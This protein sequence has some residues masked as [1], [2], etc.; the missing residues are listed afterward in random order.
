MIIRNYII[1]LF[2]LLSVSGFSQ[3]LSLVFPPSSY[4]LTN[5]EVLLNWNKDSVENST[6]TIKI[7]SDS[8]LQNQLV[9]SYIGSNTSYHVSQLLCQ[10]YY[11]K[12]ISVHPDLSL[13]STQLFRFSYFSPAC[14]DSL[15]LWLRA[16]KGVI[17]SP[18]NSSKVYKW[19]DTLNDISFTQSNSSNQPI[20]VLNGINAKP[21]LKFIEDSSI[22]I[23]CDS[24]S[25]KAKLVGDPAYY[26]YMYIKQGS[27][28][29]CSFNPAS[30][31]GGFYSKYYHYGPLVKGFSQGSSNSFSTIEYTK[32]T[33]KIGA[34]AKLFLNGVDNTQGYSDTNYVP[35][36]LPNKSYSIG[37]WANHNYDFEGEIF[38]FIIAKSVPSDTIRENMYLYNKNVLAPFQ[39]LGKD[40]SL[41]Y[42]FCIKVLYAKYLSN[43][44]WSTGSIN[45]SIIISTPGTYWYSGVDIFGR[46]QSDTIVV[47][48]NMP[49]S[50]LK[51]VSSFCLGD[52]SNVQSGF[53]EGYTYIWK[54]SQN[55]I[56]STDSVLHTSLQDTYSLKI[57]DTL[58]CFITDT[59]QVFVD[60]FSQV[61]TLGPNKSLCTGDKIGLEVG[62]N[63]ADSF[64]WNT[65][66]TDSLLQ[67]NTAG[68][69]SLIVKDTI[70][71]IAKDTINVAI[72]GITPYVAFSADTVCFHDSSIFIDQ[73]QSLDQSNLI[74]W[75]W[76]FGDGLSPIVSTTGVS[77]PHLYPDS[78]TYS[79]K[80]TVSTDSNC[81]NYAYRNVYVRPLP[82]PN[83]YPLTGCQNLEITFDNLTQHTDS[84]TSFYWDFGNGDTALQA[85]TPQA[86][87][88]AGNLPPITYTYNQ[89][90]NYNTLLRVTDIYG[91]ADSITQ[92][93]NIKP[94]PLADFINS[95]VCEGTA[96]SFADNSVTLTY[97]PIQTWLWIFSTSTSTS[98]STSHLFP[99][100]GFYPTKLRIIAVNGCWDTITKLVQVHEFPVPAFT[101]DTI[102]VDVNS[103]FYDNSS[104]AN[105]SI[106]GWHWTEKANS[107]S[108][109]IQSPFQKSSQIVFADTLVHNIN[110]KV[111]SSAGCE[112]TISKEVKSH[113]RPIAAFTTDKEYGLPPLEVQF[114]NKSTNQQINKPTDNL[115]YLWDFRDNNQSITQSP[116]HTYIDSAI[117]H[118]LLTTTNE[119]G[120]WDTVSQPIYAIYAAID[121]AMTDVVAQINNG[122]I[123]YSCIISN[124]GKQNLK[125]LLIKAKYN[126]GM[127]IAETWKGNLLS[128]QSMNYT[129][130]SSSKFP[131]KEQLKFFCIA[132]DLPQNAPQA[133]EN[134][135]N[136]S[137]CKDINNQFWIGTPYPNPAQDIVLLDVILPYAQ[138]LEF[139]ITDING[140]IL[141]TYK[142][143]AINGL[144]QISI[145]IFDLKQGSYS[146]SIRSKD[147][148]E[149]RRFVK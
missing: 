115:T 144:N 4:Q 68:T 6:Y 98:A 64:L 57:S 81:S 133:D 83:F 60:S 106:I 73:S 15:K 13:D 127:E 72:H 148:S 41:S 123:S 112:S 18:I 53:S 79:A 122:Y 146:I 9:N 3:S 34:N 19:V 134:P 74:L 110:L 114:I 38:E 130:S 50:K 70:G 131:S 138:V 128:G 1:L 103:A 20:I 47:V 51:N 132:V 28:G 58:G 65:S 25:S 142:Y 100:S 45:D 82:K 97:N 54:N 104:I 39:S 7:Y 35:N 87:Y 40:Y 56:V 113:P 99:S 55:Q 66:S 16:D 30:S 90:G 77:Q 29:I 61:A 141:K 10:K 140:R 17:V 14:I 37:Y 12:V 31:G 102:C 11:W 109:I 125:E 36:I 84:L 33:G 135:S 101:Y 24:F 85:F 46:N 117:Y 23:V 71:C 67:I 129:F 147:K 111:I 121:V 107:P 8:L 108:S 2:A 145:S 75:K 120:C 136:N 124:Y 96:T 78:G 137:R 48:G 88:A 118:P 89:A 63:E 92:Q 32:H 43:V 94:S 52:S 62:A 149:V 21:T 27:N 119:F 80:L 95:E 86:I 139:S 69:Y 5:D 42:S 93:V 126:S 143:N 49:V 22:N 105:D 26:Q 116:I 44:V 76:K 59:V 91:C